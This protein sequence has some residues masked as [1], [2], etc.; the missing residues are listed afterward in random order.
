LFTSQ[1]KKNFV[2][3][4]IIQSKGVGEVFGGQLA[5]MDV[6]NAQFV[7]NRGRNFDRID[8]LNEPEV[9]VAELQQRLRARLPSGI[10]VERPSTRGQALENTVSALNIGMTV[11][12]FVALLVGTFIIF[13]T[14]TIAVNQRWK[15][16][17]VL[18]ALGVERKNVQRMFLGEAAVM[19]L[20]GSALGIVLGFGLSVGVEF[21]MSSIADQLFGLVS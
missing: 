8:L 11:T 17:G 16:I 12:S 10:E 1:G 6:F 9:T 19:G 18:R 20:I 13:N 7:F 21:V 14:F 4:G 5:V 3:R 2:V 15:E